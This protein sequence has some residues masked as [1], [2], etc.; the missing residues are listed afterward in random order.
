MEGAGMVSKT[1]AGARTDGGFG[2]LR[3]SKLL[4]IKLF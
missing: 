1:M 2:D 4:I 3:P